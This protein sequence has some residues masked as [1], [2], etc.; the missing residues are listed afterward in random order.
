MWATALGY[1]HL[2]DGVDELV[3]IIE[4]VAVPP[5][6][7][8]KLSCSLDDGTTLGSPRNRDA[9]TP[10]ELE[11]SFLPKDL[12][13]TQHG[14][15]VH[16]EDGGEILGRRQALTGLGLTVR[17]SSPYLRRDLFVEIGR[18]SLVHL[19]TYHG[20]SNTSSIGLRRKL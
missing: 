9:S 7:L 16:P 8:D 15:L 5:R 19:D 17:N 13:R 1:G 11:E 10:T 3:E 4:T 12:Q 2:A 18:V 20:P 14:V 6:K